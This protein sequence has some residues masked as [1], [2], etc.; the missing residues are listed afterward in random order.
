MTLVGPTGAGKTTLALALL[1]KRK[2]VVVLAAKPRDPL[3]SDLRRQGYHVSREWPIPPISNRLVYWPPIDSPEKIGPQREGFRHALIDAY[4]QGGWAIYIDE[5]RYVT[6]T[7]GL[8]PLVELLWQHGRSLGVSIVGG[9]QRPAHIPLSAYS[10]ATHLFFWHS[11]DAAD[12]KRLREIGGRVD[13]KALQAAILGLDG[14]Q[15]LYVNTRSGEVLQ[16]VVE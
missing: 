1:P 14:F 16:T 9:T 15:V 3:I 2:Y 11:N 8:A 10:Q 6:D 12:L 4:R 5:L 7:L 13:P